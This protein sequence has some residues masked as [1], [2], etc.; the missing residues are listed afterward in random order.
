MSA[1]EWMLSNNVV[2]LELLSVT[3]FVIDGDWVFRVDGGEAEGL[4][5]MGCGWSELV[6]MWWGLECV[7]DWLLRVKRSD[8]FLLAKM[9]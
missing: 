1:A 2:G 8:D 7:W 9:M 6:G 3:W 5:V 4:D